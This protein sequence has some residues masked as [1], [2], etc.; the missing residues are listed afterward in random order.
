MIS[1]LPLTYIP[2]PKRY[3][4]NFCVQFYFVYLKM[5]DWFTKVTLWL[6]IWKNTGLGKMQ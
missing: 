6:T 3:I 5:L 1:T 4:C 2:S